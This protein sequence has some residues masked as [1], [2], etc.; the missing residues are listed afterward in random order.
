MS[1][2]GTK[3][4]CH[5]KHLMAAYGSKADSPKPIHWRVY[6]YTP[7]RFRRGSAGFKGL[8]FMETCRA[9]S[10]DVFTKGSWELKGSSSLSHCRSSVA[11]TSQLLRV[12]HCRVAFRTSLEVRRCDSTLRRRSWDEGPYEKVPRDNEMPGLELYL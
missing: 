9:C 11:L 10:P 7:V 3:R 2:I 1:A 5:S 4:K 12:S 6:K 8:I